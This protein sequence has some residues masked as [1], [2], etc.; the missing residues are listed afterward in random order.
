M[1]LLIQSFVFKTG[2]LGMDA[3]REVSH[4]THPLVHAIEQPIANAYHETAT[5]LNTAWRSTTAVFHLAAYAAGG[6][7]AWSLM[8]EVAPREKRMIAQSV[9]RAWKR[10]RS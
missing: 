6:Y 7:L 1:A 5:T 9:D 10:L 2:Q 8:G 3:V 4:V